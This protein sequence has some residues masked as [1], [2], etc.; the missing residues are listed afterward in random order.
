MKITDITTNELKVMAYNALAS[1]ENNQAM[2]KVINQEI[3][4]RL[5][6]QNNQNGSGTEPTEPEE[7]G[8]DTSGG[9]QTET[10]EG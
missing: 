9:V 5:Q 1:I 3:G 8:K 7:E 6:E 10:E 4:R 2:L